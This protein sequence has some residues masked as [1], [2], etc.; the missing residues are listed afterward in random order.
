MSLIELMIS[1]VLGLIVVA[2][3]GAIFISNRQTYTATDS[4]GR[5]QENA[6]V[7]F[8]LMARDVREA[9]GNPCAKNLPVADVLNNSGTTWWANWSDGV[10][11]YDGNVAMSG[12][13]FGTGKEERV[14]GTDAIELKSGGTG[15]TTVVKHVPTSA[16]FEVNTVNHGLND[17][18]IALI[19]DFRQA[20]IFQVTNAQP[21]TN[22][23][24]VHNDSKTA[25][26]GNCSKGLGIPTDCVGPNGTPYQYGPNSVIVKLSA[27]RWYIGYNDRGGMS[28]FQSVLQNNAGDV[29]PIN[30]EIAEGV[31][32]MTLTYLV[33]NQ[34]NYVDASVVTA[35]S[36]WKDVRAVRIEVDMAGQE[37][38]GTDRSVL[39][40]KLAHVAT[41]RNRVL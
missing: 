23:T 26:P 8:E 9:A 41:L 10:V 6:R 1:L 20:A 33:P 14:A 19:C 27:T 24:V 16:Q 28:L 30:Q 5:V 38:V 12:N 37:K 15:G 21:G 4:L 25:V 2:G 36:Q 35:N 7:A 22:T 34:A 3:A 18:D 29:K 31:T 11:G 17:S 39:K 13:A 32:N 40:R